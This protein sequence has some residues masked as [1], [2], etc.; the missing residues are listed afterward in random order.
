MANV[1]KEIPADALKA[2]QAIE[3]KYGIEPIKEYM[4]LYNRKQRK[5]K[6][7]PNRREEIARDVYRLVVVEGYG[8]LRAE[9]AVAEKYDLS[10][11]TVRNH[12]HNF[13][14]FAKEFDYCA[15]GYIV[16]F[17]HDYYRNDYIL[18]DLLKELAA[19]NKI[20]EDTADALYFKYLYSLKNTREAKNCKI[21]IDRLLKFEIPDDFITEKIQEKFGIEK[22][23][24]AIQHNDTK[25]VDEEDFEIPF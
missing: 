5:K 20:D 16:D 8:R 7:R 25:T 12:C 6:K 4:K 22:E 18:P 24:D 10:P 11:N 2:L 3:Q 1:I 13:D 17:Y 9:E 23:D 14:K 21:D 19:S 15:F